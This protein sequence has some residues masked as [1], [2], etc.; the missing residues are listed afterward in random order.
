MGALVRVG[1]QRKGMRYP[2]RSTSTT[3]GSVPLSLQACQ[4]RDRQPPNRVRLGDGS[5][6]R[7]PEG[8]EEGAD[9]LPPRERLR[10]LKREDETPAEAGAARGEEEE[11]PLPLA[12]DLDMARL[13]EMSEDCCTWDT[14]TPRISSSKRSDSDPG[15][16]VR[17]QRCVSGTGISVCASNESL[18]LA[19]TK[20]EPAAEDRAV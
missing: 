3:H 16:T 13:E 11:R 5:Y 14:T 15:D 18:R 9:P 7:K 8:P 19:R 4:W 17:E 10:L 20:V 6:F 2:Y 1:A 12:N